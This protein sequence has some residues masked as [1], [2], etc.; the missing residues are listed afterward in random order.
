MFGWIAPIRRPGIKLLTTKSFT[1]NKV[2]IGT[3][4][5]GGFDGLMGIH[6]HVVFGSG[7]HHL[8]V[9]ID[10]I[11]TMMVFAFGQ[12]FPH[13]AGFHRVDAQFVHQTE[14]GIQ[15]FG[16]GL[17]SGGCFVVHDQ[18]HPFLFSIANHLFQVVV[19]IGCYE[20]KHSFT[21][22]KTN[23]VF[24]TGVPPFYQQSLNVVCGC[25][26]DEFLGISRGGSVVTTG[27]FPGFSVQVHVPPDANV[28][29]GFYP[30]YIAQ[31]IGFVEVDNQIRFDE[32][33][34]IRRNLDGA[35]WSVEWCPSYHLVFVVI[36]SHQTT[37]KAMVGGI[38]QQRHVGI[39]GQVGFVEAD[40]DAIVGDHGHRS[41]D[42]IVGYM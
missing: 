35:P 41:V 25:K 39:I 4:Q 16:I 22:L 21:V 12:D 19:R 5:T 28:F 27:I 37:F 14:S 42:C 1:R 20:V 26:I 31:F 3:P 36:R 40:V 10:H 24:P 8:L 6:H 15:L 2:G 18:L 17:G 38:H 13:V 7:I 29:H 23:P 32:T 11:L 9:M 34:C 30:G 33:S